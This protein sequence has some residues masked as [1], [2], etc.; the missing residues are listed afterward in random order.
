MTIARCFSG[1][2]SASFA[3]SSAS[4][5]NV[6][7]ATYAQT[8]P[9]LGAIRKN[10]PERIGEIAPALET[11]AAKVLALAAGNG[12][13]ALIL[14]AWGCGVFRNDPTLV[15]DTFARWLGTPAQPYARR[16]R[17]SSL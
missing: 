16:R 15:A 5:G 10:E 1:K 2:F 14:G 8:A 6:S 9:N 7:G 17:C 3:R 4:V 12:C 11:R 13:D